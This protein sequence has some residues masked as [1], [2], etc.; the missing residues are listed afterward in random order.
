MYGQL[1]TRLRV[2]LF[3]KPHRKPE[4]AARRNFSFAFVSP[5]FVEFLAA[6]SFDH[7]G[8]PFLPALNYGQ[9][10]KVDKYFEAKLKHYRSV[11][12]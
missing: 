5:F 1:S 11:A 12:G 3:L 10:V 7:D 4:L 8:N 2:L 6:A 9:M